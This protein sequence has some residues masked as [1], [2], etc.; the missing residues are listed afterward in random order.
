MTGEIGRAIGRNAGKARFDTP[1]PFI[2]FRSMIQ[3]MKKPIPQPKQEVHSDT[4]KAAKN[5]LSRDDIYSLRGKFR[6]KG[7]LKALIAEKKRE[8]AR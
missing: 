7:L 6:G 2:L 3:V 4:K 8:M 1:F 5:A